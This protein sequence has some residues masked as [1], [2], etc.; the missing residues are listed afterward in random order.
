LGGS[1]L[2]LLALQR[3]LQ[4]SATHRERFV[5]PVPR[6]REARWLRAHGATAAIDISDGVASDAAHIAAASRMSLTLHLDRLPLSPGASP[7]D[8]A[9]SGEEYELLVAAP[10][11]LDA[12]AF[13]RE[14]GL[15]LTRVGTV[16]AAGST[17]S[18]VDTRIGDVHVPL[19]RGHDHFAQ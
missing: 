7:D 8:A 12:A 5:H 2:A 17:G 15:P 11:A 18:G 10:D 1:R 4:P 13:E 6:L 9:R 14:F 3:G 19:P 16:A